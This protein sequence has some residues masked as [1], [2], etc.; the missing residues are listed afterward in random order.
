[1]KCL[2]I[3]LR[4]PILIVH[5]L[6]G[7]I[8]LIF[9]PKKLKLTKNHFSI[10]VIWMKI[11]VFIFGLKIIVKGNKN[12]SSNCYA[13]NHVSFLDIMVLN[14]ILPVCFIAKSEIKSWPIVGYLTSKS[15]NLFIQRGYKESSD[16]MISSIKEYLFNDYKIMFFPEGRIG[17][18][19]SIK[20]FHSKLLHSIS[21]SDLEIQPISIRYPKKYPQDLDSDNDVA[22]PDDDDSRTLF[23]TGIICLGRVSTIVLVNF[24]KTINTKNLDA[25]EIAKLSADDVKQSLNNLT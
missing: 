14:S 12:K 17:D 20:K 3:F 16:K 23:K 18:G 8:V 22:N 7:M 6:L 25:S 2:L 15:G 13:S 21:K 10:V 1:M 5:V 19:L 4:F 24:G 9:F 11:L